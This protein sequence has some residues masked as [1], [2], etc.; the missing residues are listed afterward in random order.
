[1]R[2]SSGSNAPAHVVSA[3]ITPGALTAHVVGLLGATLGALILGIAL[4]S[5][6]SVEMP[7]LAVLYIVFVGAGWVVFAITAYQLAYHRDS[8][9]LVCQSLM[10]P[11]TISVTDL[12]AVTGR[13]WPGGGLLGTIRHRGGWL[14]ISTRMDG[15]HLV[16]TALREDNPHV[17]VSGL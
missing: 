5:S 14:P 16:L 3:Q 15:L 7:G 12:T 17:R 8:G 10:G 1:M 9:E 2:S 4:A 11:K 13:V 6:A